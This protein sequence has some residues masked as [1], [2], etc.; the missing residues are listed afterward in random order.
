L[1]T[2]EI[3]DEIAKALTFEPPLKTFVIATSANKDAH[4]ETFIRK[5]DLNS[6]QAGRFEIVYYT[7]EDL[8]DF[9]EENRETFQWYVAEQQFRTQHEVGVQLNGAED[10]VIHP[11][12]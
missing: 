4:V 10:P 11:Q 7:R 2:S 12:L 1:T 3:S 5:E 8:V 6:R 9:I